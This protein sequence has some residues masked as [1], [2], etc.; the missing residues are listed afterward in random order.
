M[1]QTLG[2]AAPATVITLRLGAR[3]QG[4]PLQA[5]TCQNFANLIG[6]SL[7]QG[8]HI[9]PTVRN[10]AEMSLALIVPVT[11]QTLTILRRLLAVQA[12]LH[13]MRADA[14][15][16]FLV[17][18]GI[19]F[20][21]GGNYIG[22]ALRHARAKLARLPE[23]IE[24]GATSD[25]A[26]FAQSWDAQ[27]IRFEKFADPDIDPGVLRFTLAA[28]PG[29]ATQGTPLADGAF[30][31]RLKRCLAEHLGPFAT[32]V[33]DAALASS[34]TPRQLVEELCSE[35]DDAQARARFRNEALSALRPP[36]S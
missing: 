3:T 15:M 17:H 27:P 16:S 25:F 28:T 9:Q 36:R 31:E 19:V 23:H 35:I 24:H 30:V 32:V 18:H 1:D 13:R 8:C 12:E 26:G 10:D 2:A 22:S 29:A 33:V 21:S 4:R 34:T 7:R 11:S 6:N 14:R 20:P 5:A